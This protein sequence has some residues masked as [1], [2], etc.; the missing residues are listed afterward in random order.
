MAIPMAKVRKLVELQ[1]DK[2]GLAAQ[3]KKKN[4]SIAKI[5]NELIDAMIRDDTQSINASGRTFYLIA[6]VSTKMV[7]GHSD[8][9]R[10][11]VLH[12]LGLD[13]LIKPYAQSLT[14]QVREWLKAEHAGESNGVPEPFLKLW[15]VNPYSKLGMRKSS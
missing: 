4:E 2:E 14:A 13:S 3:L 5:S 15:E 11:A 9:E 7:S 8:E 1:Q 6:E 12:E 10:K